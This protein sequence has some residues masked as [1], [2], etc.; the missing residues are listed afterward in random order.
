MK[1]KDPAQPQLWFPWQPPGRDTGEALRPPG[2]PGLTLGMADRPRGFP[3]SSGAGDGDSSVV[4]TGSTCPVWASL[5]KR[6]IVICR[7]AATEGP[8]VRLPHL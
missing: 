3:G 7:L 6:V 4:M 1:S 5:E 2:S 8:R